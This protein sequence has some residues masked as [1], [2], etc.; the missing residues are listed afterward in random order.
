MGSRIPLGTMLAVS[1]CTF[2][3]GTDG[4]FASAELRHLHGKKLVDSLLAV[5]QKQS[6]L[7][8]VFYLL[9]QNLCSERVI[10][11]VLCLQ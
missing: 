6:N 1:K 7:S 9:F 5:H 2:A 11:L 3:T 10:I 4:D 8:P